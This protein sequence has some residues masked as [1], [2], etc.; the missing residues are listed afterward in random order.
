MS[1]END[2]T[3]TPPLNT[4][5]ESD[6]GRNKQLEAHGSRGCFVVQ[7]VQVSSLL[8]LQKDS[9]RVSYE[10]ASLQGRSLGERSLPGLQLLSDHHTYRKGVALHSSK[11][12]YLPALVSG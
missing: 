3:S 7:Q 5:K 6:A 4:P 2:Q 8:C 9:R 12:P 11:A 10:V 1:E